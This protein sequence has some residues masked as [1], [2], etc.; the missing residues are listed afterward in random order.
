METR[1]LQ[2]CHQWFKFEE[3]RTVGQVDNGGQD[4]LVCRMC[5]DQEEQFAELIFPGFDAN[6]FMWQVAEHW[7]I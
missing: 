2:E 5:F 7:L 1:L 6:S 4:V 3:F